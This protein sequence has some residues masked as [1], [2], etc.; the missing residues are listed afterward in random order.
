[1]VFSVEPGIYVHGW[2]GVRIGDT[3][4][5]RASG[6]DFLTRVPRDLVWAMVPQ[7]ARM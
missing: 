4:A 2:G 3:V 5:T 1:M 7:R 6:A